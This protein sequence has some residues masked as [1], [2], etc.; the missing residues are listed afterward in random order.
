MI[1]TEDVRYLDGDE[2]LNG[3]FMSSSPRAS[4]SLRGQMTAQCGPDG[5]TP[6]RFC[7]MNCRS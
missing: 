6:P 5:V 1:E 3:V 7:S 2:T 4:V